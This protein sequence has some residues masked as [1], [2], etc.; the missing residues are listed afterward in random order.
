MDV[1]WPPSS[2]VGRALQ[3]KQKSPCTSVARES[4]LNAKTRFNIEKKLI[5]KCKNSIFRGSG[6]VPLTRGANLCPFLKATPINKL[7]VVLTT[8]VPVATP[9]G[10][11]ASFLRFFSQFN[12]FLPFPVNFM[13]K[14]KIRFPRTLD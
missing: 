12:E 1:D 14:L 3:G 4:K 6:Q 5:S 8:L 9:R 10:Q 2:C 11:S 13:C 7:C